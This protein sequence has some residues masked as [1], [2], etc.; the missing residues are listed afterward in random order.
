MSIAAV[1][2]VIISVV[3]LKRAAALEYNAVNAACLLRV[4]SEMVLFVYYL[5]TTIDGG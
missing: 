4:L 3:R 5:H 1:L 2:A